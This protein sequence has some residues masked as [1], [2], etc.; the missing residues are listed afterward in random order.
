M[1]Q[2]INFFNH[3]FF[4]VVGST[5]TLLAILGF[6]YTVWLVVRGVLPVWYRLGIGLS[7]R[8]IA[9]FAASEFTSLSNML[10]DSKIFERK[11]II[12]IHKND[13][14]KAENE[15][16]FLIHWNEYKDKIDEILNYKRDG[17]ALIVYAPQNEGRINQSD[18]DKITYHRNTVVV[19]FR[20]RL[21]NDIL[22][23]LITTSFK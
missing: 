14:S 8:K 12:Q 19:N 15:T 4:I 22:T 3:P 23:S 10:E 11:N 13:L 6:S 7:R 18:M 2:I 20:G 16:V 21:L 9:I 5:A 17:T 1:E